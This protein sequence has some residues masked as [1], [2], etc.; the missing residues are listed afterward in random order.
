MYQNTKYMMT[1]DVTNG[2]N[3]VSADHLKTIVKE[4]FTYPRMEQAQH[5]VTNS[6]ISAMEFD[7]TKDSFISAISNMKSE[8]AI[9]QSAEIGWISSVLQN[10]GLHF[11]EFCIG[12]FK[13]LIVYKNELPLIYLNNTRVT[14]A[15]YIRISY[16]TIRDNLC[17]VK[18]RNESNLGKII[19]VAGVVGIVFIGGN[20]LY[21]YSDS[22]FDWKR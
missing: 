21:R 19:A 3:R 2:L 7:G 18:M 12:V 22:V 1:S 17:S 4:S 5:D 6:I 10:C 16:N 11:D 13:G 15:R 9:M 8:N 20:M 14:N